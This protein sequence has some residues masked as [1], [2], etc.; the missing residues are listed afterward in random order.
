MLAQPIELT[1][2]QEG[3]FWNLVVIESASGCWEWS[4][5][6]LKNGYGRFRD[7]NGKR[8]AHRIAWTLKNGEIPD[9][10]VI[11]HLCRNRRCVN[12]LHLEVT[13]NT[14]NILIGISPAAINA[15]KTHCDMGHAFDTENTIK[16]GSGRRCRTCKN[17]WRRMNRAISRFDKLFAA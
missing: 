2:K 12:V 10:L 1:P 9:G 17:K 15:R 5:N 13:T 14:R 4:G 6:M 16:E 7:I 3:K 11:N 8:L